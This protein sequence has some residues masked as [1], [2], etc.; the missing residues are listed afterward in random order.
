MQNS[1]LNFC[2]TVA[3]KGA[4]R[5]FASLQPPDKG[6]ILEKNVATATRLITRQKGLLMAFGGIEIFPKM[7]NNGG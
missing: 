2:Q 4:G 5:R 3:T 1:I 6:I 7:V